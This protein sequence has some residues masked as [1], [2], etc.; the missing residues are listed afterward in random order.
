[1]GVNVPT[2]GKEIGQGSDLV[3]WERIG[4]WKSE[5]VCERSVLRR[6]GARKGENYP[7]FRILRMNN[8]KAR[9]ISTK[10]CGVFVVEWLTIVPIR[11]TNGKS[12]TQEVS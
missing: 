4:C 6:G 10:D 1:M 12:F 8:L 2:L 7:L 9:S 11:V 5:L 3:E